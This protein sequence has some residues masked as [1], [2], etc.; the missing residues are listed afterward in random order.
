MAAPAEQ[1][2]ERVSARVAAEAWESLFRAQVN[3]MRR[4]EAAG[5]FA[6]IRSREYDVLFT[7]SRAPEQRLRLRDLNEHVLLSQP[8]LSRMV[9]RLEG[10][11]LVRRDPATDDARG[12]VVV[13]TA[14]GLALQRH[15]ARQHVRSIRRH[16]G[17]ALNEE[18]LRTLTE[19][20][21]RLRAYRP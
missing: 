17:G 7:L 14:E 5:D 4:F 11:G 13:L 3:L 9:E 19:L 6:P 12:L 1:S 8:S 18:E 21:G 20:T 10:R 2:D 16:V 15:V